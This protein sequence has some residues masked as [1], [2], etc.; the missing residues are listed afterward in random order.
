VFGNARIFG[1][2]LFALEAAPGLLPRHRSAEEIVLSRTS[3]GKIHAD[4][5]PVL[6]VDAVVHA[7]FGAYPGAMPARYEIDLDTWTG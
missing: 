7:P 6:L 1:T 2:N 5:R 4:H 3:S